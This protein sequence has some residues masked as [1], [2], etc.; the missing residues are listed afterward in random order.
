MAVTIGL[1]PENA[2][3]SGGKFPDIFPEKTFRH[4]PEFSGISAFHEISEIS[5]YSLVILI[6][7]QYMKSIILALCPCILCKL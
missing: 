6:I 7:P 5:Q 1:S 3:K 2:G 4:F